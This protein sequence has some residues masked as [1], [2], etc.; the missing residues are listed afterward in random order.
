MSVEFIDH[1]QPWIKNNKLQ[2]S[3]AQKCAMLES[4]YKHHCF[5]NLFAAKSR[6]SHGD[7]TLNPSL[8]LISIESIILRKNELHCFQGSVLD[9]CFVSVRYAV[10]KGLNCWCGVA[11]ITCTTLKPSFSVQREQEQEIGLVIPRRA[12]IGSSKKCMAKPQ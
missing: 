4:N 1:N 11:L 2:L 3:T 8:W 7:K 10:F 9:T 12:G 5:I 6:T